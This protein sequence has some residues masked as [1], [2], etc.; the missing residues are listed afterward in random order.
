MNRVLF[1]TIP[2]GMVG[3]VDAAHANDLR[4]RKSTTGHAFCL[5]GGAVVC[6]CKTQ[7][8]TATSSTEAEFIAAVS[9]AKAARYLRSILDELG[10]PML[11]A[12]TLYEDNASAIKMVNAGKPTERSRHIDIQYFAIQQWREADEI[13][14]EHIP[15]VLNPSDSLTKAL[16]WV[17]HHRHAPRLMGHHGVLPNYHLPPSPV[18]KPRQQ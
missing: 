9:A 13:S 7:S 5:A 4:N 18:L 17:L 10:Y 2:T 15:G 1:A 12:T 11:S 16:G 14:M 3:C 6:K 8:I